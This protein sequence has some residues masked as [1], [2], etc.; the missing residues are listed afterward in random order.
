MSINEF[1]KMIVKAETDV[2]NGR[3]AET[4]ALLKKVDE[5]K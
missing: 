2:K 3:V 5:W 1:H 4:Q